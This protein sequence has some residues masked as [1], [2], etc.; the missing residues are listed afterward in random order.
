MVVSSTHHGT[1]PTLIRSDAQFKSQLTSRG[2]GSAHHDTNVPSSSPLRPKVPILRIPLRSKRSTRFT[3]THSPLPRFGPGSSLPHKSRS[4][5]RTNLAG[6]GKPR[7]QFQGW[8][9]CRRS[10]ESDHTSKS[11]EGVGHGKRRTDAKFGGNRTS[12]AEVHINV[13]ISPLEGGITA[14][15]H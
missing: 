13:F 7:Y 5:T 4:P 3:R 8:N 11:S 14:T 15:Q 1:H 9:A 2:N 10:C 6:W 12:R